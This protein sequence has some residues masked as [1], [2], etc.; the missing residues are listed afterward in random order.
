M[1]ARSYHCKRC[2]AELGTPPYP[3]SAPV[4]DNYWDGHA[5]ETVP[6]WQEYFFCA[7]HHAEARGEAK[8]RRLEDFIGSNDR[9]RYWSFD[10]FPADDPAGAAAKTAAQEWVAEWEGNL[11]LFGPVGS[12]KT[13]LAFSAAREIVKSGWEDVRFCNV[14]QV[15]AELRRSYETKTT[16]DPTKA[17]VDCNLLVLDDLGAERATE[18]AR[19]TIATLVEARYVDGYRPTIVTTNYSPSDLAKR[20]GHDDPV[21]GQRIVSRL[22]EEAIQIRLDRPDLRQRAA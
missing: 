11:F 14:R 12:G 16:D 8:R 7:E 6:G 4:W 9:M 1:T 2:N 19:E 3:D 22:T 13:G 21:L 15:L 20:L 17:L 5:E 18:W 10:T